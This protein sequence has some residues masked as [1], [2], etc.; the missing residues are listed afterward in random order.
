M[1]IGYDGQ[2]ITTYLTSPEEKTVSHEYKAD[3]KGKRCRRKREI[4][5]L[6]D[7]N[8]DIRFSDRNAG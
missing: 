3:S 2:L 1:I 6:A 8:H 5:K 7:L 4:L